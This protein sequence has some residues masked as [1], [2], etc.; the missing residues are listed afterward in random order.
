M[1]STRLEGAE[2]CVVIAC[3]PLSLMEVRMCLGWKARSYFFPFRW[4]GRGGRALSGG[5]FP[6]FVPLG[7]SPV[8]LEPCFFLKNGSNSSAKVS[9]GL[10]FFSFGLS[11]LFTEGKAGRWP[12]LVL[13]TAE[14][15]SLT[16]P[17]GKASNSALGVYLLIKNRSIKDH[18]EEVMK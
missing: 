14:R 12:G 17:S 16:V 15:I 8:S 5:R 18:V 2:V 11:D 4:S 9:G 3:S 6:D 10:V 7:V 1:E 13:A